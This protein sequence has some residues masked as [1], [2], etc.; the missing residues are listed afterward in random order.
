MNVAIGRKKGK[1]R[2]PQKMALSALESSLRWIRYYTWFNFFF[3]TYYFEER[4]TW[5]L[6][7]KGK[8]KLHHFEMNH[9]F[10][11]S[12]LPSPPSAPS[13]PHCGKRQQLHGFFLFWGNFLFF[14]PLSFMHMQVETLT[15][16][17]DP[18]LRA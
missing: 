12:L 3:P 1:S 6:N 11:S 10:C 9:L 17:D 18:K 14:C 4:L 5:G 8:R 16:D 13:L 15:G 7:D 2:K